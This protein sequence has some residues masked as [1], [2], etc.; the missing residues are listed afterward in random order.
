ML[1]KRV[2]FTLLYDQGGFMLSRNFRLQKVGDLRWLQKNYNFSNVSFSIDELVILDVSR[3][4]RDTDRFCEHV[5]AMTEGSFV[6]IAAGGGVMSTEHAQKLLRAGAD[7]VV[8][9]TAVATD[10]GLIREMASL[11]G[12]QCI[13]ASVDA[14]QS[15]S[16]FEVFTSNGGQATET[17]LSDWIK[18][19]AELPVGEIYLNS[20]DRDGTGQGYMLAM[21][22]HIPASI[23]TPVILA[24]GAGKPQHLEE[25]LRDPRVDAVA[26]A[27]LFNF[28]GDGLSQ[29]RQRLLDA[30]QRLPF[31]DRDRAKALAGTF[32]G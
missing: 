30:G 25:G 7:K 8:V 20:M 5:K 2:I 21:L 6:P 23:T 16:G 4:A 17:S 14:K 10:P 11:Y 24:G 9:N 18:R 19:L 31:W 26:T 32:T 15:A 13:V 12:R 28:V 27:H 3:T 1:K 22:D 29:A